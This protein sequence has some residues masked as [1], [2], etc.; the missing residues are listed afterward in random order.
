MQIPQTVNLAAPD[1]RCRIT[2]K[3]HPDSKLPVLFSILWL[4]SISLYR[5]D[6]VFAEFGEIMSLIA[7]SR[8]KATAGLIRAPF[9]N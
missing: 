5:D 1:Y 7:F 2:I 8:A 4:H 6:S 3:Y 9:T